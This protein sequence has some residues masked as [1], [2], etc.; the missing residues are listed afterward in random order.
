[1]TNI[2]TVVQSTTENLTIAE[3]LGSVPTYDTLPNGWI[4]P[5]AIAQIAIG[6]K[7]L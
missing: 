5:K 6:T 3:L 2:D 4:H 7:A 1:M